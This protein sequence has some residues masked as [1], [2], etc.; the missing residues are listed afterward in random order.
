LA[1]LYETT[2]MLP[3]VY[4]DVSQAFATA[5]IG[6]TVNVRKPAVFTANV[7]DR[8]VGIVPQNATET[9]IPVKLDKIA[10]VSFTVTTEDLTLNI[11]DFAEQ[12]LDPAMEA[13]AQHV[14]KAILALRD[15]VVQT[16]GTGAGFEWNKPEV[17]IE[18][19]RLLDIKNVPTQDRY[20]V[21]GPTTKA[22]WLNTELLKHADKSGTTAAL[23]AGS[24]GRDVFGF[25]AFQ[26]QNVGQPGAVSGQPSTEQGLAF[27]KTAFAFASAPL[28]VAPGSNASVV[29]YKGINIRVAYD[30]D[31]KYKQTVVSL[32]TLYGVKTLD[33]NRAVL[34]AGANNA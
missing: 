9:A 7:F 28:E 2:Q 21:V 8:A 18:A 5:K 15:D 26:T 31:I 22:Q 17:L 14:D 32:D 4:T 19:G 25:Q 27:H 16:A 6:D 23:R 30:Y 1:T 3:L 33:A 20:A 24:I 13:I 29:T 11:S 10:D 34:L 12:F